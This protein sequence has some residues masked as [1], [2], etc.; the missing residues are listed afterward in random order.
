MVVS[1]WVGYK[2]SLSERGVVSEPEVCDGIIKLI[3][4]IKPY[5]T[6][7]SRADFTALQERYRNR[8]QPE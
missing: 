1:F 2:M 8:F 5:A 3:A 7:A 4:L 6:Q